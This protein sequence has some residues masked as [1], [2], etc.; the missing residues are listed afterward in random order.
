[1]NA[2]FAAMVIFFVI[3]FGGKMEIVSGKL[4]GAAQ[5]L[6]NAMTVFKG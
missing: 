3:Y 6:T 5:S 2:T 4:A 1:M